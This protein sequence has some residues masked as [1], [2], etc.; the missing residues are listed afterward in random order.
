MY[1]ELIGEGIVDYQSI[2]SNRQELNL[3]R[4]IL[5]FYF[6]FEFKNNYKIP[7]KNSDAFFRE[8]VED[9]EGTN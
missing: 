3:I 9:Y 7:V 8:E 5:S 6:G 2:V 4:N 1:K